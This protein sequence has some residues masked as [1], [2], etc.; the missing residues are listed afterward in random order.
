MK[1]H[2]R[3]IVIFMALL[4]TLALL[5]S[6]QS[7]KKIIDDRKQDNKEQAEVKKEEQTKTEDKTKTQTKIEEETVEEEVL[8]ADSV[9]EDKE[10]NKTYYGVQVKNNRKNNRST[11]INQ[12]KDV[13]IKH[14][15][16]S[17]STG[18]KK[19]RIKEKS[20]QK[21]VE[22]TKSGKLWGWVFLI[23]VVMGAVIYIRRTLL[24]K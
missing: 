4:A 19:E 13:S 18:K 12:N 10:G 23:V 7:K 2:F 9:K 8:K 17:D 24:K 6:C 15:A 22:E 11:H 16:K 3:W 14:T 21:E 5:A 20:R 1:R